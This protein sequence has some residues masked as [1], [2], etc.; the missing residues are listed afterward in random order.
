MSRSLLLRLRKLILRG[1]LESSAEM[2]G[3]C[4]KRL[5][6]LKG[7]EMLEK[8]CR[9]SDFSLVYNTTEKMT[10]GERSIGE[11]ELVRTVF[12]EM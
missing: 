11:Q 12:L 9:Y 1:N 4:V 3:I 10:K 2:G 5:R 7:I 6:N 8:F